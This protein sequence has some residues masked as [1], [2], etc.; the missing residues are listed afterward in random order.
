MHSVMDDVCVSAAGPIPMMIGAELFRQGPRPKAMAVA[1][2]VNW[3]GTFIIALCFESVAVRKP[4][5]FQ[6]LLSVCRLQRPKH[7]NVLCFDDVRVHV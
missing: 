3:I 2:V 1:S 6:S 7:V 5:Q 4:T